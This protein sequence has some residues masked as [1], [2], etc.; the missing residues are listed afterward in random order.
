MKWSADQQKIIDDRGRNILVSAAAGSGKTAVMVERIINMI[1]DAYSPVS[2]DNVVIM[3]FTDAAANGMK[4]KIAAALKKRIEAEPDNTKLKRQRALLSRANI[5]TIHSFC[6]RLIKQNYQALDIDPGFRLCDDAES[7][8][9]KK[10]VL[11]ELLE[12]KY[13]ENAD[14]IKD[15]ALNE[16]ML[17]F[18]TKDELDESLTTA[19][20][21]IYRYV[22]SQPFPEEELGKWGAECEKELEGD[23]TES[24]WFKWFIDC[25]HKD[26]KEY[27]ELLELGV[28][29]SLSPGGP[30]AYEAALSDDIAICDKL[31]GLDSYADIKGLLDNIKYTSL[32][33][34]KRG[35]VDEDKKTFVKDILRAEYKNYLTDRTTSLLK[36]YF[37]LSPKE[38]E[39]SIK[40]EARLLSALIKLTAEYKARFDAIKREKNIL[41]FN[42]LEHMAVK[43][44]YDRD[45][46]RLKFSP[47]ADEIAKSLTQVMIDEYQDSS[48][49]QEA[50]L[51]AL[52]GERFGNPD[53]F[54]VGDVKQSIYRFRNARPEIFNKKYYSFED[55]ES[56]T[57]RK[58]E[59]DTNFRSR[60]E[61][62][63]SVNAVF[64]RIMTKDFGGI[65]YAGKA[66]LSCGNTTYTESNDKQTELIYLDTKAVK[67]VTEA[68]KAAT[69]NVPLADADE[70]LNTNELEARV[71]AERIKE[72]TGRADPS[73]ALKL[74]GD[75]EDG[76]LQ[77]ATYGDITILVRTKKLAAVIKDVLSKNDIPA[78]FDTGSGYYDAVEVNMMMS[79]LNIIDNPMQDIPLVTV[80]K[81]I[82]GDFTNDEL[83]LIRAEYIES[84][85]DG[86]HTRPGDY[87]RA[88]SYYA[89]NGEDGGLKEKAA[90]FIGLLN[91]YRDMADAVP[92][93]VLLNNIYVRT[94]Y[95]DYASALELGEQRRKNL[96]MLLKKAEDYGKTDYQ[97]LFNFVRYV[98]ILRKNEDDYGEALTISENDDVVNI[99]TIHGSKGLEYPV[100]FLAGAASEFGGKS[101]QNIELSEFGIGMDYVEIK[102]NISYPSLK[103]LAIRKF[104]KAEEAAE[105]QRLLYVA[106]TRAKEKLIITAASRN[107]KA[108]EDTPR[109]IGESLREF[110]GNAD[111]T[112]KFPIGLI[113]ASKSYIGWLRSAA[114][115]DGT[116][117]D[118]KTISLDE[119]KENVYRQEEAKAAEYE[120]IVAWNENLE[121]TGTEAETKTSAGSLDVDKDICENTEE[122]VD[123]VSEDDRTELR[124]LKEKVRKIFAQKYAYD[125]ETKLKPKISVSE[126][127]RIAAASYESGASLYDLD[128]YGN[129]YKVDLMDRG[130]AESVDNADNKEPFE[131]A[132]GTGS[133][134][135]SAS[136][137][138]AQRG[139]AYH[140][141]MELLS[142]KGTAAEQLEE[143]LQND[144]LSANDKVLLDKDAVAAFSEGE[145]ARRMG[146]AKKKNK[147]Y[148]EQHFMAGFPANTLIEGQKSDELQLLQGIID[149]YFEEDGELV[150]VDYKTDRVRDLSELTERYSIQ[151]KLYKRA[152]EQLTGMRV[153]ECI[154]YS[155]N[156]R[157]ELSL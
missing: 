127:K 45:E 6:Q 59:L 28:N 62:L 145:L 34:P 26:I 95:Y 117:I 56:T 50:L 2:L 66:R 71:I 75:G 139:T 150:L 64:D 29:V 77:T 78:F 82:I 133:K 113:K 4:S 39:T 58:I 131:K 84:R 36:R 14:E 149:A 72:L 53:V 92:V 98:E 144:R 13:A 19:I 22:I 30:A 102:T 100:V 103:R 61:V 107:R 112:V 97:G 21:S 140:R 143:L 46:N 134:F 17:C 37:I 33:G 41:D 156:L 74:Q 25:L 152:L 24:P 108:S 142:Y 73:K 119:L 122:N 151:L 141:A 12:E 3:T 154:I 124:N 79:L 105:E 68:D 110:C 101:G 48:N 121:S 123:V 153:K 126:I 99:T 54:M 60:R 67:D 106:M 11:T 90:A 91:D 146:E 9:L 10:D 87:F 114:A 42:D 35:E 57:N 23:Y 86:Y 120:A 94:G 89:E 147:L 137:I 20:E 116:Y 52:S 18:Q 88:L 32:N 96:D 7:K 128:S 85:E 111:G 51:N 16:L 70:D 130:V 136:D 38:L 44:L 40:G 15:E 157:Q 65:E 43:L 155:T 118:V 27:K 49:V 83:A 115:A 80:L 55:S 125:E 104:N 109:I 5:S 76:K 81:G 129:V 63:D 1:S 31:M 138:A 93:H 8:M 132:N 148:R 47:L 69:E 135:K